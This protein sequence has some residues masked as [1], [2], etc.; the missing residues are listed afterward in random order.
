MAAI[1]IFKNKKKTIHF[2]YSFCNNIESEYFSKLFSVAIKSRFF[3]YPSWSQWQFSKL[4]QWK[5]IIIHCFKVQKTLLP[6]VLLWWRAPIGCQT[7]ATGWSCVQCCWC[8]N[9]GSCSWYSCTLCTWPE[10]W[11]RPLYPSEQHKH[12]IVLQVNRPS[13]QGTTRSTD[14]TGQLKHIYFLTEF[15]IVKHAHLKLHPLHFYQ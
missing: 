8:P 15:W 14:W 12:P 13:K 11:W 3:L 6:L 10:P 1:L 9:K 7:V 4:E 5:R 2:Y